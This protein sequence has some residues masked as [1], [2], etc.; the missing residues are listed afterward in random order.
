MSYRKIILFNQKFNIENIPLLQ[1]PCLSDVAK[2]LLC[3]VTTLAF[4]LLKLQIFFLYSIP[5][6]NRRNLLHLLTAQLLLSSKTLNNFYL[7]FSLSKALFF[8]VLK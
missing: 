1:E 4:P 3:D 8:G 6:D 2:V 7:M 5:E